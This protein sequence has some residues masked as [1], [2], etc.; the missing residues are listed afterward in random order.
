MQYHCS[1]WHKDYIL[2]VRAIDVRNLLAV[3]TGVLQCKGSSHLSRTDMNKLLP[4]RAINLE[5]I[6]V[7]DIAV[8]SGSCLRGSLK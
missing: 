5:M 2:P 7:N 8:E 4:V 3:N 1:R 6:M